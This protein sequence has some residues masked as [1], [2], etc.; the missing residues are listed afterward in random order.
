VK[1][2][3]SQFHKI[4]NGASQ[5]IIP[6]FQRDY[7]WPEDRCDQL[8]AD[9]VRIGRSATNVGH[10]M[11]SMVYAASGES[12]A[13]LTRW[14]LIDGQ[15]RMTT[16]TLLLLA[17]RRHII[18]EGWKGTGED[19]PTANR[20]EAYFLKNLQE[21]GT[22]RQKLVLRRHDHEALKA[23]LDDQPVPQGVSSRIIDNF[24]H[25]CDLIEGEDPDVVYRGINRLVVV[26]CK[27]DAHDD[28]QLV[29]ESL[30]ST[31]LDLSQADL[32]RNF[33][34]M[35]LPEAEQTRLY[36]AQWR[37]IEDLFRGE[38]RAFDSFARDY[39]AL[40][41]RASRQAR[42]EDIY[43]EFR[44]FFRSQIQGVGLEKA[45]AEMRRHARYYAAFLLDRGPPKGM[46]EAF[47]RLNRQAE[48]S[49]ILV[50]RLMDYWE[51]AKTL[52]DAQL[53]DAIEM[54]ESYVFRRSVCGLQSRGYWQ[55]FS[56][57]A[58]RIKEANPLES[59]G[60][61]LHAQRE[62]N[63]FPKDEEFTVELERRD[64]YNMRTCHYLL[65][66]LE[67]HASKEPTKTDDY[68]IEHVM[69][70]NEK[71]PQAWRDMLGPEWS[72]TQKTWIHRLGNLT[73]TGYNSEYSDR[74]FDEKKT[75]K[76]GFNDSSVRL[77]KYIREQSKWSVSEM[78]ARGKELASEP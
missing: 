65:D 76:G 71:M 42:V 16:L 5:F 2:I 32:I 29:F 38:T 24:E 59:L 54:L 1:A 18:K 77:N 75:I 57:L 66:R 64:V 70:Q 25:F 17:L 10:F 21:E 13:T 50:M 49:A 20:I 56:S 36:D 55:L 51:R 22:R 9:V 19:S 35:R 63:R 74:S 45:L 67:N 46:S 44:E 4:I 39:L 23:L 60:A 68:T 27:L 52:T 41:T 61:L 78:E 47:L 53:R 31:G 72:T 11:G 34:L 37:H 58:Y 69:P 62:G 14:L 40:Q 48:V 33:I 28:P 8:W 30:N 43:Y 15:Q 12:A 6:V 73:L 3:D 7:S 26:D